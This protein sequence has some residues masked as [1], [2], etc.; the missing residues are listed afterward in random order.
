MLQFLRCFLILVF[1]AYILACS[2]S[3]YRNYKEIVL[4]KTL[5]STPSL[6]TVELSDKLP[7]DLAYLL[8]SGWEKIPSGKMVLETYKL[9]S[10]S[11]VTL[12]AFPGDV[13]GLAAN[14]NRWAR[15]SNL[16]DRDLINEVLSQV[17][18]KSG[19]RVYLLVDF[20]K[21]TSGEQSSLLAA[22]FSFKDKTLFVK[23]VGQHRDL[24]AEK[25]TFLGFLNSIK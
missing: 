10:G 23:L 4:T 17:K 19:K 5:S 25:N 16:K 6:Q 20:L 8:P 15:Q 9:I 2:K 1:F 14:V 13:G 11:K 22:I 7:Q 12:S 3:P 18:K 21:V 24:E